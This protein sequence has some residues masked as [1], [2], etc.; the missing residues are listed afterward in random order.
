MSNMSRL[1]LRAKKKNLSVKSSWLTWTRARFT[2]TQ[3][4]PAL[5]FLWLTGLSERHI[6]CWGCVVCFWV[7]GLVF[8]GWGSFVEDQSPNTIET[9]QQLPCSQPAKWSHQALM[10][11]SLL[12]FGSAIFF[13]P[14][15]IGK[16]KSLGFIGSDVRS[17]FVWA[18]LLS[19]LVI[20]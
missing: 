14:H 10:N 11:F 8:G 17:A 12:F 5:I 2:V 4:D 13:P 20:H 6:S 19:Y 3:S 15:W 18:M 9:L 1:S 16:L 7:S